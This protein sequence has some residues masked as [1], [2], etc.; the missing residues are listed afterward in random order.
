MKKLLI[1]IT[2][3][4]LYSCSKE[5]VKNKEQEFSSTDY[6]KKK[7]A[8][9]LFIDA[10]VLE[11]Q[12]EISKAI[13]KYIEANKLDP[14]AG[15]SFTIAKNFYK[16]NKLSSALSYANEAVNKSPKN[17]EYLTLLAAI[18]D[19]S[20][21]KDSSAAIYEKI[22][23]LDSTNVNALFN[24]AD[25]YESKRPKEAINLYKKI[26][27]QIGPDWNVLIRLVD[28]NDRL[29][30]TEETIKYFEEI[31]SINPSD[32]NLQK[33]LIDL[34]LKTKNFD[35]ALKKIDEALISYPD[36]L[37]L[38]EYKAMAFAQKGDLKSS[39][40]EYIKLIT[41]KE[42]PF[43]RKINVGLSF[44]IQAQKDS[45]SLDLAKNIFKILD[46]DSTDWQVKVYLGE[47]AIRQNRDSIA[48]KYFKD[49][50]KLAEWNSQVWTRL[51]GLLFDARK[52]DDAIYFMKQAVEK[53]PND[54]AINLIYGLSLSQKGEHEDA[55]DI[56]NRALKINPNDLT[57]LGAI[58]YSLN[59]LNKVDDALKYLDKALNIDPNNLQV[60]SIKALIHENRKEYEISDSLYLKALKIDSTNVLIL[61]NLAYSFAERGIKLNEALKMSKK[62]IDTEPNNA[63]YLDTYGWINYKLGN[64]KI[65]KEYL[66]KAVEIEPENSTLI[67]HLGDVYFKLG[68]RKKSLDFWKKAFKLDSTK[69]DIQQKIQKE[70]L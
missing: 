64:Y 70:E 11:A 68:N 55:V 25:I 67:D 35:K 41:N 23:N 39:A 26:I 53:F 15:I 63:S 2:V 22:I 59:Q 50:T 58:G 38:I 33:M 40:N 52:Y 36:D 12:G 54:F 60:I 17:V 4:F 8:Q 16:Q 24:L 69:T 27:Q 51:G 37:N 56:L 47:I 34:Y 13:E 61:N 18:Y 1:L 48:I 45:T 65:A 57:A 62:S 30:N 3:L 32:L 42:I 43:D 6:D 29:G 44:L 21:I 19:A 9:E 10:S 20:K 5:L 7:L 14:Q 46:K 28:I 31:A 49:A 66:E